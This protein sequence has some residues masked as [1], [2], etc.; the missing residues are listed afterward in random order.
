MKVFTV[1]QEQHLEAIDALRT[2]TSEQTTDEV[3]LA[4]IEKQRFLLAY[5]EALNQNVFP[6]KVALTELQQDLMIL[7]F[8]GNP[9]VVDCITKH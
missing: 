9:S 1:N 8:K 7:A 2:V 4:V 3:K 6:I 5:M